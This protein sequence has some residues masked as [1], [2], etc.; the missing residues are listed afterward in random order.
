MLT[1]PVIC[2][3]PTVPSPGPSSDPTATSIVIMFSSRRRT[4]PGS[5]SGVIASECSGSRLRDTTR[6][7]V[8]GITSVWVGVSV[9]VSHS[10]FYLHPTAFYH[11]GVVG[12][13]L[14]RAGIFYVVDGPKGSAANILANAVNGLEDTSTISEI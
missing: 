14:G 3:E 13:L 11:G 12:R 2:S 10:R 8:E 5:C 1:I 6:L 7:V 4:C 9:Y